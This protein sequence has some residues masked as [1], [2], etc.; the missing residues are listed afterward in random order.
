MNRFVT[1]ALLAVAFL[2]F[3]V[4]L[5]GPY[6]AA[7]AQNADSLTIISGEDRHVFSVE[8]ANTPESRAR[9]LM[10][11]RSM[12]EDHGMLFDFGRVEMVSMWMR[13]TYIPLDM[14]FVR[15]DGSIARIARDTEPLSERQISSGE[16]VLA[17][18]EINAGISDRLGITA[19][20]RIDHPLF[21]Q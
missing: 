15:A 20:D 13:N 8:L 6:Q 12:P 7:Q 3:S 2:A 17:V 16:P 19:G 10:Y 9:G 14:L 4:P 18:F 11:R 21:D 5:P 1:L